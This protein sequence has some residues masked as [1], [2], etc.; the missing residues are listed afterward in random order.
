MKSSLSSEYIPHVS[1]LCH[2]KNESRR[3]ETI[4]NSRLYE[5]LSFP[6]TFKTDPFPVCRAGWHSKS[7]TN[8]FSMH[9]GL[10][11]LFL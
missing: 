2:D 1:F 9:S 11:I 5:I 3:Q 10:L 8:A 6:P 4:K 7:L